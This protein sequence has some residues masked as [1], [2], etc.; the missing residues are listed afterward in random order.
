VIVHD[1]I[2]N[3]CLSITYIK[4]VLTQFIIFLNIFE[5]GFFFSYEEQIFSLLETIEKWLKFSLFVIEDS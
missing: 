3:T 5:K 2:G 1:V 4:L